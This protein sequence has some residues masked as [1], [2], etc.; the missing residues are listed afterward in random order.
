MSIFKQAILGATA[1][2]SVAGC[3]HFQGE[4]RPLYAGPVLP[5]AETALL[6]GYVAKVDDVD[7]SHMGGPFTLLPGCHVITSRDKLGDN[8]PSGAWSAVMPQL[9]FPLRMQAG[10]VYEIQARR[11]GSGSETANLKMS[12][13]ELD[14]NGKKLGEVPASHSKVDLEACRAWEGERRPMVGQPS[15]HGEAR[16]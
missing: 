4:P 5:P 2:A 6:S 12:A 1:L 7:V 9:T 3:A 16:P 10:H 11:Q 8:S 15:E 13:V 14:G